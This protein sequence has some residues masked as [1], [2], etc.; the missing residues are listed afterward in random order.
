MGT[1]L[2]VSSAYTTVVGGQELPCQ[3]NFDGFEASSIFRGLVTARFSLFPLLESVLNVQ[4]LSGAGQVAAKAAN[5]LTK[6][7]KTVCKNALE[8]FT[9]LGKSTLLLKGTIFE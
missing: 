4:G 8:N 3:A 1:K 5:A 9:N 7:S 6:V 2:V